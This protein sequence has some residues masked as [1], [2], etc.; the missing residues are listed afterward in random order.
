MGYSGI[1]EGTEHSTKS[2]IDPNPE[3]T[4]DFY[5]VDGYFAPIFPF[6]K[7]VDFPV[8]AGVIYDV[9]FNLTKTLSY[10]DGWRAS[11]SNDHSKLCVQE[12]SPDKCANDADPKSVGVYNPQYDGTFHPK[13]PHVF[14][15][16]TG[17]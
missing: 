2:I 9:V 3:F 17:F 12:F 15:G 14:V 16:V 4:K 11:N 8:T 5:S 6:Q 10:V 13:L 7:T 1:R